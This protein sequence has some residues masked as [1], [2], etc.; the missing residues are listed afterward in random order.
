MSIPPFKHSMKKNGVPGREG[1]EL[2]FGVS[3][4]DVVADTPTLRSVALMGGG[5]G[6]QTVGGF[7]KPPSLISK[8]PPLKTFG[9]LSKPSFGRR[10]APLGAHRGGQVDQVF[11]VKQEWSGASNPSTWD[12]KGE[13]LEMVPWEFPLERTHREIFAE[14]SCVAGRISESLRALSVAA[15][16]CSDKAKAKCKTSDFVVFRI[17]LFAGGENGQPVV[18][19]CQRRSGASSSFMRTCRAILNAA[20]G[21]AAHEKASMSVPPFM[22]RPVSSMKCLSSVVPKQNAESDAATA[23]DQVLDMLRS[24]KRDLNILGLENLCSLTDPIKTSSAVA[25]HVAKS[26]ILGEEK[27]DVREEIRLLTERDV[28]SAEF[29]KQE[30]PIGQNELMHFLALRVFANALGMCSKEGSLA[31]AVKSQRWFA[32]CLIPTLVDELTRVESSLNNSFQAAV[33]LDRKSVV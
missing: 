22:K 20:E 24:E 2:A 7:G 12:V 30:G 11:G 26:V 29:D 13:D 15:E 9:N 25:L 33:C 6:T 1:D 14:A 32:D 8:P 3:E 18:V 19:E 21:K 16:Y 28:F 17:R 23:M 5:P 4:G 27:Y 31:S 10:P